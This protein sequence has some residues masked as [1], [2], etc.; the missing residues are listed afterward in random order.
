[1]SE[2]KL[3]ETDE[4]VIRDVD[5]AYIPNDEAN[6]D[7]IEYQEWLEAGG[8][9]QSYVPPEPLPP[10]PTAEQEILFDH[11]NRIRAQ[12]GQPPLTLTEFLQR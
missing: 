6:R 3:T 1:M 5:G 7:W 4:T 10:V 11:E 8:V 12:E 9:P 2:Y